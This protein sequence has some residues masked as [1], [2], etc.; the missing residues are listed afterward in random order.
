MPTDN[1]ILCLRNGTLGTI[2]K[3]AFLVL[4]TVFV[5]FGYALYQ[6]VPVGSCSWFLRGRK[7]HNCV[8]AEMET[9]V[10]MW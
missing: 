3:T 7:A 5:F 1:D 10:E 6:N 2:N 9:S 4:I 8:W